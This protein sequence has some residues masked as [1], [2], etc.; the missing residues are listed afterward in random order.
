LGGESGELAQ[1]GSSKNKARCVLAFLG[2][3]LRKT[4][5]SHMGKTLKKKKKTGSR[6]VG[7]SSEPRR[8][9]KL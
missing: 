9:K 2:R 5:Y 8:K 3:E 6:A 4:S 7:S 1:K